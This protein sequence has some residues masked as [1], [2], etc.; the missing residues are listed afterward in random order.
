MAIRGVDFNLS[1]DVE[2]K[3]VPA[4]SNSVSSTTP[5][6]LHY[7]KEIA[8]LLETAA[9]TKEVRRVVRAVRLTMAKRRKLSVSVLSAF[10]SFAFSPGSEAHTRLSSYLLMDDEHDMDVDTATSATQVPKKHASPELEIYCYL[11]VL[12]FLIDQKKYSEVGMLQDGKMC[13]LMIPKF[14]MQPTML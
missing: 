13:S 5:T 14:K 12:I 4:P 7:L 8:S 2:M 1:Q 3:E 9:Y 10:L 6:T 11:L